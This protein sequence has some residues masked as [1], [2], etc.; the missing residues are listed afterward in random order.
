M[1][2]LII[3]TTVLVAVFVAADTR[4]TNHWFNAPHK[5]HSEELLNFKALA[6]SDAGEEALQPDLIELSALRVGERQ[7]RKLWALNAPYEYCFE[8]TNELVTVPEGFVFDMASIPKFARLLYDPADFPEASLVHD[9]LYALG[10][11]YRRDQ[12]DQILKSII[13]ETG[14][15]NRRAIVVHF[16]VSSFGE[17]GY[18]LPG[19]YVFWDS[20]N[21]DFFTPSAKPNSGYIE[22]DDCRDYFIDLG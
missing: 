14:N 11:Q 3:L 7:G 8:Q 6:V 1:R 22:V 13:L 12:A 18:N 21:G 16:A 19:D 5:Q 4:F 20:L 9:W 2:L 10:E 15:S 17:G